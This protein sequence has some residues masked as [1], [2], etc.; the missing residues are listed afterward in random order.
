MVSPKFRLQFDDNCIAFIMISTPD[1][2]EN[3]FIPYLRNHW[4]QTLHSDQ[5]WDRITTDPIDECMKYH[6]KQLKSVFN[7]NILIEI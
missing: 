2:F 6:L 7:S 3:A 5:E 1:M 4:S